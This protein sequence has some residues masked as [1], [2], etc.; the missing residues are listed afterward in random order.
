MQIA[1]ELSWLLASPPLLFTFAFA[2]HCACTFLVDE[3]V[4]PDVEP[5]PNATLWHLCGSRHHEGDGARSA[6][7]AAAGPDPRVL[8]QRFRNP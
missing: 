5:V 1:Q 6:G 3:A 8:Q 7:E 2:C 4:G